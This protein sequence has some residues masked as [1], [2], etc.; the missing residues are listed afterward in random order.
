LPQHPTPPQA[1]PESLDLNVA[2]LLGLFVQGR[3]EELSKRLIQ[4]LLFLDRHTHTRLSPE[5]RRFINSFV[6]CL[7]FLFGQPEYV[8]SEEGAALFIRLNPVIANAVAM[9]AFG[10]TDA[11]LQMLHGQANNVNKVLPLLSPRNSIGF[12]YAELFA[13]HPRLASIWYG[14]YFQSVEG[15]VT[16]LILDNLTRHMNN[17]DPR[18]S[19]VGP[20]VTFAYSFSTYVDIEADRPQKQAINRLI[21]SQLRGVVIRNRPDPLHVAVITGRWT[22]TS[23][24]Y[25]AMYGLVAALRGKY[26]LTLVQLNDTGVRADASLFDAVRTVAISNGELR[27]GEVTDN[28]FGLVF[29]PDLGM[30]PAERFLA[31]LRLAPIQVMGLGHSVSTFGTEIDYFITGRDVELADALERNYSERPVLIPGIGAEFQWREPALID[32]PAAGERM[33]VNCSWYAH[34]CR[35]PHLLLLRRILAESGRRIVFRFFA[36]VG[37]LRHNAYLPFCKDLASV[38]GADNIEVIPELPFGPYMERM[39][40]A[41]FGIDS[42][43]IGG[44]NTV[45]DSLELARPIVVLEGTKYYNRLGATLLRY[46]G[47]PEL[48]ARTPDEYVDLTVRLANDD[49]WRAELVARIRATDLKSRLFRAGGGQAFRNAI[50]FLFANHARLK[51]EGGRE[52]VYIE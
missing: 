50:D 7:L 46:A 32:E 49:A 10:T 13:A 38:L 45:I 18:Y 35:H 48:I 30:A 21:R 39:S 6:E 16:G 34:R 14:T 26:R 47:L 9:S 28:D 36:G 23:S 4:A 3:H 22:P 31:N 20:D 41:A 51:A 19:Y 25:K 27:V 29:Y 2:E 33:V 12:D 44:G 52:P 5:D 15:P 40:E 1:A 43:P 11:H 17:I 8:L 37:L 24:V 42:Y